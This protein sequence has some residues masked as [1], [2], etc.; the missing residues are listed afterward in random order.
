MA[1]SRQFCYNPISI[2]IPNSETLGSM[3]IAT[4]TINPNLYGNS[5]LQWWNG[6][7]EDSG[8]VIAYIDPSGNR[9]NAPERT[10]STNYPCNIG[11]FRSAA[12]TEQSFIDLTILISG[13]TSLS[14]GTQS[15]NWLNSNGYWTSYSSGS[16]IGTIDN[17]AA[18]AQVIY[19]SGQT[20]SGWY[21][22]KTSQMA[23]PKQV[24]CNM[25]DEGGGWML[26]SYNPTNTVTQGNL[27]PNKWSYTSGSF[28][29]KFNVDAQDLWYNNGT[30][31]CT[32]V[33][34]MASTT[35]SLTPLLSGMEIANKVIYNNPG[36]LIISRTFS[37]TQSAVTVNNTPMG[38]SWSGIKGH[39]LMTGTLNVN[40]P[41]DWI[42]VANSV[43]WTVCGPSTAYPDSQGRSGNGQGSGSWTNISNN[44]IYGMSNVATNGSSQRIDIKTY[45]VY[46]K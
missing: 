36:N 20:T 19:N 38:G 27:Y 45:A 3:S 32:Q 25:T 21:Y 43:W 37:S 12:K 28:S 15:K 17:P 29:S 41:G 9:P 30:Y 33:M 42:Y 23:S 6:P 31:Q 26:I 40:A 8:Y 18:S 1:T 34:K 2:D 5:N 46:I 44:N 22:I 7:D 39:T 11:F 14:T 4:G 16:L 13:S 35:A 10:F 24:Y